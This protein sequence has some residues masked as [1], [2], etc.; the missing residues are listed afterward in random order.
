[1][2]CGN[3]R[4]DPKVVEDGHRIGTR[5]DCFKKGVAVG[6]SMPAPR[7]REYDPIDDRKMYCGK[8]NRLPRGYDYIGNL[9]QCLQKGVGV[10]LYRR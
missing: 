6:A 9:A 7:Y 4:L 3:N 10:G 2:Y 1:M 8:R 5:Y